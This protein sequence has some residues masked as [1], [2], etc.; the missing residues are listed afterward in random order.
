MNALICTILFGYAC[1]FPACKGG[2]RH[3]ASSFHL[4]KKIHLQILEPSGIADDPRHSCFWIVDGGRGLICKTNREGQVI[5]TL[6]YKGKDI[7]GICFDKRD[8]TLWITEEQLRDVVHLSLRGD[9]IGRI[10]VQSKGVKNKG[11]EG[12]TIDG[13]GN[14]WVV[15][16]KHPVSLEKINQNG[17]IVESH[18]ISFAKD[19]SDVTVDEATGNF[20]LLSDK[21]SAIYMW[22]MTEG[23]KQTYSLPR[24]KYEGISVNLKERT[25]TI[26]N[27]DDQ[28]MLVFGY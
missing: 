16:E 22:S 2:G 10:H 18:E 6:S 1:L 28:T 14:M 11:V 4:L 25:I 15:N 3:P 13:A 19:L 21:S 12:V 20:Y 9:E 8:A 17:N 27:D 24:T 23:L 5:E 26:V 7:E